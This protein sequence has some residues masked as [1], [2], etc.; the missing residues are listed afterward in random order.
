MLLEKTKQEEEI[1]FIYGMETTCSSRG[2]V[3]KV[4]L[5]DLMRR[6]RDV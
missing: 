3:R 4:C 5:G 1:N 6:T 2:I